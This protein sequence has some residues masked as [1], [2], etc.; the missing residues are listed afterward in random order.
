MAV[1]KVRKKSTQCKSCGKS[2]AH[3]IDNPPYEHCYTCRKEDVED[4]LDL[5]LFKGMTKP[6]KEKK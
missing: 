5:D 4:D 6:G 2:V 1:I 3:N